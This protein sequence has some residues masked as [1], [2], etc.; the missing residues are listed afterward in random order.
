MGYTYHDSETVASNNL[1]NN[2][3]IEGK[4]LQNTPQHSA[5]FWAAYDIDQTW[6]VGT[7]VLYVGE[8]FANTSNTNSVPETIRWDATVGYQLNK[9]VQL[10]L[11]AINLTNELYF[12]GVHPSHVI[13]GPSRTF[14]LTGNFTY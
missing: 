6:Q 5:S 12:A 11:N 14:V 4:Q 2:V 1:Q 7:G 13:P 10:R 3:S 8:R 9:H